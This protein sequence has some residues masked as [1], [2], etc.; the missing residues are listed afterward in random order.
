MSVL[1]LN[2]SGYAQCRLATDPDP[3]NERR[4]V[5][6]YTFALPGEPDLDFTIYTQQSPA[7]V[8]RI[9]AEDRFVG[10]KV[11]GGFCGTETI[12]PG[13]PL[14]D[15]PV[16]LE[17]NPKFM[18]HNYVVTTQQFGV[19][20]PFRLRIM[21]K[22]ITVFRQVHFYPG[23]PLDFPII[24]TPQSVLLPYTFQA[25]NVNVPACQDL[26]GPSKN[27][28]VYR[29][30]RL[31]R[32]EEIAR[33]SRLTPEANAAL[34]K[35]MHEL[36][37]DDPRDR[38]TGQ[39]VNNSPFTYALNGPA[40]VTIGAGKENW[41]NGKMDARKGWQYHEP[42]EPLAPWPCNFWLGS[43]DAD[44]LTM[45]MNGTLEAYNLGDAFEIWLQREKTG[46][47]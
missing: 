27:P 8:N 40:S 30:E 28:S 34:Q 22:G 29:Q 19:I 36:R 26:M 6:G 9:G 4:G 7:V 11:T 13:H 21:G 33:T 44:S 39:L 42:A 12:G 47:Q 31:K 14:Y 41:L 10:V 1:T 16:L 38:R 45:Y 3:T 23:K 15:A 17:D 37:M 25:F 20:A 18:E 46:A 32:L 35:R 5:S 43:W 2:F 24:E